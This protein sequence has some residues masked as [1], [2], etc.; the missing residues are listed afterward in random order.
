MSL[1]SGMEWLVD[2]FEC[3][4]QALADPRRIRALGSEL[5]VR[6]ELNVIGEPQIHQFGGPGGVT[7]LYLLCESHLALHTYP[8]ASF[9]TL[10]VYCC[11][12]RAAIDWSSLLA[13]ALGARRVVVTSVARGPASAGGDEPGEGGT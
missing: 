11:R 6:L 4:A 7:A 10:N 1:K 5:L 2:A 8:E 3:D 13:G 9:A 12:P